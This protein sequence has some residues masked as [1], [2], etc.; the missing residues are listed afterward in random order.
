MRVVIETQAHPKS[1]GRRSTQNSWERFELLYRS[2]RDDIFAY[3]ATL[4]NDRAAAEDVTA[5]AFERAY[6]RRMTFDRRRGEERAWLFGI[7]RNAAL[8]ELRR[9]KRLASLTVD[10]EAVP[11][12]EDDNGAEVAL[13][14]TVVRAALAELAPRDREVIAL[15]F[16]SGLRN[17]EL[18]RV[19]GVS[20]TAAGTLLYRAMEKLRKACDART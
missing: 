6:R 13:R 7:A 19:L 11:E 16:H 4:L 14:R 9:R 3:V 12:T 10:P 1:G 15:K 17:T 5:L 18:A 8:D 2:S 20:E